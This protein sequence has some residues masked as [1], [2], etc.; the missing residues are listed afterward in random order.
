LI[1][2]AKINALTRRA[3]TGKVYIKRPCAPPLHFNTSL[4]LRMR[5]AREQV[6]QLEEACEASDPNVAGG[7]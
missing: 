2:P 7:R 5:R 3:K 4:K 1:V 6:F